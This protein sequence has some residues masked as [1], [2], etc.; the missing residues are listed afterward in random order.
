MALGFSA[1]AIRHRFAKGRLHLIW[2][3]VYAVG[4]P[5]LSRHGR[6]MAAVLTC[7]ERVLSHESAAALLGIRDAEHGPIEVSVPIPRDP[8][9][10]GLMVHRRRARLTSL[11][12]G[13]FPSPPPLRRL[14]TWP[15]GF[16]SIS[17]SGPSTKRLAGPHRS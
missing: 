7:G 9:A 4:R 8:H 12:D 5:E 3:G 17:S 13:A 11:A 6:W 14:S 15:H 16:R 10:P 2:A 1:G